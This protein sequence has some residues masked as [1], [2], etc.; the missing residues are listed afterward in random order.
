MTLLD[1]NLAKKSPTKD[2]FATFIKKRLAFSDQG[3]TLGNGSENQGDPV[4]QLR[5][6]AKSILD[7]LKDCAA[8]LGGAKNADSLVDKAS[9]FNVDTQAGPIPNG[10]SSVDTRVYIQT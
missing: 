1:N 8:L 2:E 4:E 3:G 6:K 9:L 10:G 5:K 7:A